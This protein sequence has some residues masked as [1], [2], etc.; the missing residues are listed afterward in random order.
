MKYIE[1]KSLT[2]KNN[3]FK[4]LP[5]LM[6]ILID[7]MGIVLVMPVLTPL[8]L[9]TSSTLV[10]AGTSMF[11][12]DFLYGFTMA[13]FPLFVFFSTPIL[14]D[15]SDKF[16]RKKIL[17]LC[18]VVGALSYF[19]AGFAIM[20]NSLG[21][22][23]FGRILAGLAS[24][25]Q[26]IASGALIDM[27]TPQTKTRHLSWV[28]LVSS[29]GV[30]IGPLLGGFT[31]EKNLVS[32]FGYETPFMLAGM[33][34]LLNAI[35]LFWNFDEI[36]VARAPQRIQLA[37]GF[38]LFAAAFKESKFRLLSITCFCFFLAW[39]LYYQAICWVFMQSF[40]YS[41]GQ[42][43]GFVGFIGVVY[44]LGTSI[45]LPLASRWFV[46]ETNIYLFFVAMMMIANLGCVF[47]HHEFAQWW[48]VILNGTGNVV[49]YT[50]ALSLFSDLAD[51]DSQG[52]IMGSVN[53][54]VSITWAIG[55][56][57][58]GPLGFINIYL[59]ILIAGGLCLLSFMVM[60]YYKRIHTPNLNYLKSAQ[61]TQG[62]EN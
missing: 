19:I 44:I 57:L 60:V 41:V 20:K 53:A 4:F 16:G 14:G 35:L 40:G 49:C 47:T 61:H 13:L 15:L 22:F 32:W 42:L 5:L 50:L 37:K 17:L 12:R 33:L 39:C 11:M 1:P 9:Q 45:V 3:Y 29:V 59:P 31:A 51:K 23:L 28:V 38:I 18:L 55:G 8:I 27:S 25:T 26:P 43:G 56:L 52:W 62:G 34:A 48:W 46:S 24:G 10:P 21:F 58:A 6:V 36:K 2:M 30:I 54:V 7:V